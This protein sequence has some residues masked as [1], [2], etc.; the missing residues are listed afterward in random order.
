MGGDRPTGDRHVP[1]LRDRCVSLLAPA[2]ASAEAAGRRPV[3]VD[4]T[5]GMG[6]HSQTMLE[7]FPAAHLV[8]I[9]R[10]TEALGLAG[11]RLAAFADRT[12]L[13]HA[14]DSRRELGSRVDRHHHIGQGHL[15]EDAFR[16][17]LTDPRLAAAIVDRR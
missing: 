14:N 16:Y 7:R 17:L 4:A 10:D 12:D 5:L 2:V 6:G 15:G 8:G 11:E 13:I 9:D 3:V 1:V